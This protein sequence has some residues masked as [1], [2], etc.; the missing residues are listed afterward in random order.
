MDSD[1]FFLD[2]S[3]KSP[4]PQDL[5]KA[6]LSGMLQCL[7][8]YYSVIQH[9]AVTSLRVKILDH[10]RTALTKFDSQIARVRIWYLIS[11]P[12]VTSVQ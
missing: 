10:L 12:A 9:A 5:S 7:V 1:M 6:R 11:L 3:L 2:L 4:I 8:L